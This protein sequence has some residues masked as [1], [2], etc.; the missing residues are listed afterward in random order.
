MAGYSA[1]VLATG[2]GHIMFPGCCVYIYD[3]A[4]TELSE[5]QLPAVVGLCMQILLRHKYAHL[6][7][8]VVRPIIEVGHMWPHT[9]A[10]RRG[11]LRRLRTP[12]TSIAAR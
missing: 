8:A 4:S 2:T 1:N 5:Y 3:F 11:G 6:C 7:T 12:S 10:L 9:Q